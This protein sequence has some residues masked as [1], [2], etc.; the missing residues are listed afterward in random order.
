[1][2]KDTIEAA[3]SIPF[4]YW[5]VVI[6]A[7]AGLLSGAIASLVAPW[8]HYFIEKRKKGLELKAEHIKDLKLLIDSEADLKSIKLSSIWPVIEES[9]TELERVEVKND[10]VT[11]MAGGLEVSQ[12]EFKRQLLSKAIYRLEKKWLH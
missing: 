12:D 3:T 4:D 6:A 5:S 10:V 2:E 1:M 8:V 7:F 9:L 11:V